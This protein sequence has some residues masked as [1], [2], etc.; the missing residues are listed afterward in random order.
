MNGRT[1]LKENEGK[2]TH[3]RKKPCLKYTQII[4]KD[5]RAEFVNSF[6][7][8]TSFLVEAAGL[9]RSAR[10]ILNLAVYLNADEQTLLGKEDKR[11]NDTRKASTEYQTS[12]IEKIIIFKREKKCIMLRIH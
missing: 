7:R 8:L 9:Q 2:N 12:I 11:I 4:Y 5:G 10:N 3:I 6:D 1:Q